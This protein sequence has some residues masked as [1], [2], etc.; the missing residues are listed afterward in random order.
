MNERKPA[1]IVVLSHFKRAL[2]GTCSSLMIFKVV[3]FG[4][5]SGLV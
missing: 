4:T 2:F 3:L 1:L 5:C